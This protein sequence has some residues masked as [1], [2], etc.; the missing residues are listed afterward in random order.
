MFKLKNIFEDPN[1]KKSAKTRIIATI[2][3][4]TASKEN[5]LKLIDEGMSIARISL[6]HDFI[7]PNMEVIS[8]II[9]AYKERPYSTCSIMVDTRGRSIR[10][11]GFDGCSSLRFEKNDII[12]ISSD[13]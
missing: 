6:C 11:L 1:Y 10:L 2:G 3:P 5:I 9:A 12:K 7:R 8:S 4:A 13:K